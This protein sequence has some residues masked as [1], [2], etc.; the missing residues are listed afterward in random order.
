MKYIFAILV[1]ILL[2]SCA[3]DEIPT[4]PAPPLEL[5]EVV[6]DP[7]ISIELLNT[8]T[9]LSFFNTENVII[10]LRGEAN[11]GLTEISITDGTQTWA[12]SEFMNPYV[13]E[14]SINIGVKP[15]GPHNLTATVKDESGLVESITV[16]AIVIEDKNAELVFHADFNG[17]VAT[18]RISNI[19]PVAVGTASFGTDRNRVAN[20][21]YQGA[22]D[23]YFSYDISGA[24]WM[25]QTFTISFWHKN[26]NPESGGRAGIVTMWDATDGLSGIATL[27]RDKGYSSN[28]GTESGDTWCGSTSANTAG[29]STI[30]KDTPYTNDWQLVTYTVNDTELKLYIDGELSVI[31]TLTSPIDWSNVT[32][33]SIGSGLPQYKRFSYGTTLGQIDDVRIYDEP[34]SAQDIA[35]LMTEEPSTPTPQLVFNVDFNGGV[36]KDLVS[37]LTP[38]VVG[39]P[40]FG[41]DRIST[42]NSAYQGAADSYLNY[43]ITGATWMDQ[44]LTIAFWHKNANPALRGR[45]GIVTIWDATD[46]FSGIATLRRD[47]GYSSNLGTEGGDTWC[48]SSSAT[49]AGGSTIV[50]DIPYTDDWQLV[51]YTVSN[52][53]LKLY[54]DGELSVTNTLTSPIDWSN[55]TQL[56]IGSGL[57][58]YKRYSYGTTLGQIDEVRIYDMAL[59]ESEI[60]ALMN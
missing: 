40:I 27:R 11:K 17:G 24:T 23:S 25:D 15:I 57:P 39:T 44:D 13:A 10:L 31:N 9:G 22:A 45:A 48:G 35:E 33:L 51:V 38:T 29:G 7:T 53:E 47:K 6:T 34:L 26:A 52:D 41:N 58:Q 42:A 8:Q 50:K 2:Y 36:A 46:G 12:E 59:T 30:V 20:N 37:N 49:A 32:Q 1:S 28:I 3:E 60:N 4:Y 54:V 43:D 19:T 21:T 56:S 16:T 14:K 55:V 18:D 5:E